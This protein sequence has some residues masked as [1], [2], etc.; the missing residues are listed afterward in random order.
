V[1]VNG[2]DHFVPGFDA[3]CQ[4]GEV[5]G[6][7]AG[8]ERDAAGGTRISREVALERGD[9]L[10]QHELAGVEDP[11]DGGVDV[12]LDPEILPAQIDQRNHTK[13][14]LVVA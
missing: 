8:V 1:N 10:A 6:A 12:S 4:Q 7:R 9:L 2:T 3:S 14:L 13:H 5:K 11:P